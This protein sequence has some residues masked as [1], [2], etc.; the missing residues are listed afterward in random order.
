MSTRGGLLFSPLPR[1]SLLRSAAEGPY[2][3][4]FTCERLIGER[5]RASS[6]QMQI[7]LRFASEVGGTR[8]VLLGWTIYAPAAPMI[9]A[10]RART[11]NLP[12]K[13]TE[14]AS[15]R[16]RL[17]GILSRFTIEDLSI[18]LS[19]ARGKCNLQVSSAPAGYR[20]KER[21]CRAF[22]LFWPI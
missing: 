7:K 15:A 10:P 3:S 11:Y 8:L 12:R 20:I 22:L 5:R 2:P 9:S 19:A 6:A 21:L 4:S 1:R 14:F 13:R 18:M 16:E 17:R